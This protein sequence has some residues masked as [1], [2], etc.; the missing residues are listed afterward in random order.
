MVMDPLAVAHEQVLGFETPER[1]RRPKPQRGVEAGG[2]VPGPEEGDRPE[3][4]G[5]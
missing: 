2:L 1:A 5:D 4:V 3:R